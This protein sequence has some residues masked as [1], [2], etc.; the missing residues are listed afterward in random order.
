MSENGNMARHVGTVNY[1]VSALHERAVALLYDEL[2]RPDLE[3][4]EES[5]ASK[6]RTRN[7]IAWA[8]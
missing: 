1:P 5:R 3:E 6:C 8:A 7:G 4:G 2:T